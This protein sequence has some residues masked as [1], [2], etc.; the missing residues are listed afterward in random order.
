MES[1]RQQVLAVRD[2]LTLQ[3]VILGVGLAVFFA[4]FFYRSAWAV[5]PMLPVGG[6]FVYNRQ[7]KRRH[8]QEQQLLVEF[9]ECVLSVAGSLKAGYAV[10]NAF[11]E[12]ISDIEVMFG[13]DA[14]MVAELEKLQR[15]L[16]NNE[17]L[18]SL[19]QDMARRSGLEE[20]RE[21]AEVFA[22]AKRNSGNIPDTIELYS[23]IISGKLE[24][25]AE[26]Q[27]LLAAKQ[28]EQKVMNI[29]PFVIVLYLEYSNPGYFDM[30]YHSLF[31][32]AVMTACLAVYL[33]AFGLSEK[34][35]RKAFG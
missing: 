3:D 32:V 17:T 35:F 24:L 4:F 20:I 19:L 28:L 1:C 10:E 23:K 13:A 6:A 2:A 5:A 27:T 16:R 30:M 31:G 34:I 25:E 8:K 18:E 9:K 14:R 33:C 29:M 7:Q 11:A 12:S 22:I 15:G 26:L 21:F